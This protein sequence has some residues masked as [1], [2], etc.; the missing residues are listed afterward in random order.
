MGFDWCFC[1]RLRG[2]VDAAG[3]ADVG[4]RG[5]RGGGGVCLSR[6]GWIV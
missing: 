6:E 4:G 1:P 5:V 3:G 2:L